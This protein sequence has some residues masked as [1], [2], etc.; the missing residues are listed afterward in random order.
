MKK[1][2]GVFAFLL[3]TSVAWAQSSAFKVAPEDRIY[4]G[5]GGGFGFG[6]NGNGFR[7]SAI[8]ITPIIGVNLTSQWSLGPIAYYQTYKYPDLGVRINQYGG[9]GFTKYKF[10]KLFAWYEYSIINVPSTTLTQRGNYGR[11]P[12][13]I[14]FAPNAGGSSSSDINIMALYDMVYNKALSPFGSPIIV[15]VFIVFGSL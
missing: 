1:T 5:G 11:M 4:G 10:G 6:T 13:G 15:R 12:L 9:G 2:L 8:S 14:G 3:L 7:Y